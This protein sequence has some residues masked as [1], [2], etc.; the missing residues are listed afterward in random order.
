MNI[1]L[2]NSRIGLFSTLIAILAVGLLA[3]TGLATSLASPVRWEPDLNTAVLRAE[4]EHR[5]VFILFVGNDASSQQMEREV[6]NQPQIAAHLN[7]NF[8]MVRINAT[9]NAAL[10]KKFEITQIPTDLIMNPNGQVV[11]RR[12]GVIPAETF[13][14][15]LSFLQS[16]ISQ[17]SASLPTNSS[18]LPISG[19]GTNPAG[20][21][22]TTIPPS[23]VMPGATSPQRGSAFVPDPFASPL[24]GMQ[25]PSAMQQP[26]MA[27]T[28]TIPASNVPPQVSVPSVRLPMEQSTNVPPPTFPPGVTAPPVAATIPPASPATL[29]EGP[30][31][32]KMTV[33]VPLALEGCCPITLCTE[34]RWI[35]GNPAYCVMYQGHIFRFATAEALMTFA[36]NPANYVPVAMGEDIVLMVDRNKRVNGNRDFGAYYQGRVFL[37]SSQASFEA[38]ASRP[39]YYMEIAMKYELARKEQSVPL[40]Y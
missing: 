28:E 38:F 12:F 2:F 21:P 11:N 31:P 9:E 22:G 16:K 18:S 39:G 1:P 32:Y 35:A 5:H 20:L 27:R 10:V 14:N 23:A 24:Q 13:A 33:E 40:V 30:A 15:Y 4:R 29:P 26:N 37:F 3:D 19:A 6:L 17:T 8:V 25:Q 36:K 7:A 34:E